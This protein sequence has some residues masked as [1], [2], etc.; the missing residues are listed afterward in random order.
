MIARPALI[1]AENNCA[2]FTRQTG[3]NALGAWLTRA[4][5]TSRV[6]LVL[7][8]DVMAPS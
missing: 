5:A 7:L 8:S 2:P 4:S 1:G 3:A 6:S